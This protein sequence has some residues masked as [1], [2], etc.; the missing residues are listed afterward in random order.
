MPVTIEYRYDQNL[1][2]FMASGQLTYEDQMSVLKTFYQ[3]DPTLH[4]IWDLTRISGQR[5]TADELQKIIA[6]TKKHDHKRTGGT[7][8]LVVTNQLDFGIARMSSTLAEIE[9]TPWEIVSFSTLDDALSYIRGKEC[10]SGT[11]KL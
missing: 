2:I 6:Y 10:C 11:D 4:V 1:T 8:A 9:H 3:N 7:T 5:I